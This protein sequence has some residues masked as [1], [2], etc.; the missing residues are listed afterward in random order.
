MAR[1]CDAVAVLRIRKWT[2]APR[3]RSRGPSRGAGVGQ[4]PGAVESRAAPFFTLVGVRGSPLVGGHA[5][6]RNPTGARSTLAAHPRRCTSRDSVCR[7][8]QEL[9]GSG[10][11]ELLAKGWAVSENPVFGDLVRAHR[12]GIAS[13]L[14]QSDGAR[15]PVLMVQARSNPD[16]EWEFLVQEGTP[17]S[18]L[19]RLRRA[20]RLVRLR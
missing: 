4:V 20:V 2:R 7:V 9:P 5:G 12:G 10:T 6:K 14:C 16:L 17:Q 13:D 18:D 8:G 19:V 3:P 11:D 15:G 1:T